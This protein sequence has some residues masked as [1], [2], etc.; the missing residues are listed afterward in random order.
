MAWYLNRALTNFRNEVNARWPNRDKTS[1]GTVGDLAHQST[2]SDHNPD[3]DGSVDAWDM[4]VDGV[5]VWVVIGAALKHESIQ[6]IIYDRKITSRSWGL[7]EW[8]NYSGANPHDKHVHFNTRSSYENS[9]K[10]WFPKEDDL[11][12]AQDARLKTIETRV[13]Y[14]HDLMSH[15]RGGVPEMD[16]NKTSIEPVKW[17]QRL[18]A[19]QKAKDERDA[20]VVKELAEL[21]TAVASLAAPAAVTDE[22]LERVLRKVIGSVDTLPGV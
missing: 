6:Y 5:P 14:L 8:R 7:G 18:E 21:K 22:Q 1:D 9:T 17:Q 19:W 3:S 11:D 15:W 16:Y 4:D 2:S 12:A 13:N 20:A 10:P